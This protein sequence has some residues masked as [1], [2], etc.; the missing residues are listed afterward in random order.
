MQPLFMNTASPTTVAAVTRPGVVKVPSWFTVAA[1]LRVARL[2]G[3]DHLL[4]V[5]RQRLIGSVSTRVLAAAPAGSAVA[6]W[7]RRSEVSVAPET[8]SDVA[9]RLMASQ[10]VECL[11]VAPGAILLGLV[12]LEDLGAEPAREAAE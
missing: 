7:M 11:P 9:R 8:P 10:G 1:A 3:A 4:V 2:K 5:E 6:R 12:A